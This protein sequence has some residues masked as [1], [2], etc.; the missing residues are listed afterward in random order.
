MPLATE[1]DH[2]LSDASVPYCIHCAPDG[3]LGPAEERLERFTMWTMRE[4][5][6]DYDAA[7]AKA[8]AYMRTMPAWRE[9]FRD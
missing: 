1:A 2:A 5:G 3:T 9:A 8:R 4:E 6:L 7:R